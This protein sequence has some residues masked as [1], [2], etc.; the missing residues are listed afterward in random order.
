[1]ATNTKIIKIAEQFGNLIAQ[2]DYTTA[3]SLLTQ[4][5]QKEHSPDDL[6]THPRMPL[7]T[8]IYRFYPF[9]GFF[10]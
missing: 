8:F 2:A 1:M 5:A 10:L 6:N 4:E 3:Q 9:S 7:K